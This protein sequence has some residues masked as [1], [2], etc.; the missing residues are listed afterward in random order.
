MVSHSKIGLCDFFRECGSVNSI[1]HL[2]RWSWPH[3]YLSFYCHRF[4]E[5]F[6]LIAS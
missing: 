3:K 2:T 4:N 5:A 1:A 6:Q